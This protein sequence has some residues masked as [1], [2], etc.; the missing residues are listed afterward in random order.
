MHE[1]AP[2][3]APTHGAKRVLHPHIPQVARVLRA[4]AQTPK[5]F[6]R[7]CARVGA[8]VRVTARPAIHEPAG[9]Q[10]D[11]VVCVHA[12]AKPIVMQ[13]GWPIIAVEA[14]SDRMLGST[15]IIAAG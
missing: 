14:N 9:A 5:C 12:P 13:F 10:D 6:S 4:I 15:D 11:S 8:A 3:C 2:A 1:A 7:L